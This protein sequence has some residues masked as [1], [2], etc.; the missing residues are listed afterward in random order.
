MKNRISFY[1]LMAALERIL[2]P[3]VLEFDGSIREK[4]QRAKDRVALS[5]DEGI[6]DLLPYVWPL[7][8]TQPL[9]PVEIPEIPELSER[10][11]QLISVALGIL[12][13]VRQD[14]RTSLMA[15]QQVYY[16]ILAVAI[17][18]YQSKAADLSNVLGTDV[19]VLVKPHNLDLNLMEEKEVNPAK[20]SP[21]Q[22]RPAG[23]LVG[24]IPGAEL[25]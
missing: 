6:I 22:Y 8:Q 2:G 5:E 18:S 24:L 3:R 14:M 15:Q 25:D 12:K 1:T 20:Y 17:N 13:Q 4:Y 23:F 21:L 10:E 19:Q 7:E 9:E 16:N 11:Q